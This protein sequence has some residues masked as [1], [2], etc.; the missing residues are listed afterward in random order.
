M[1]NYKKYWC[2]FLSIL[3][4]CFVFNSKALAADSSGNLCQQVQLKDNT[5]GQIIEFDLKNAD[6]ISVDSSSLLLQC[7]TIPNPIDP[8]QISINQQSPTSTDKIF[9][10]GDRVNVTYYNNGNVLKS[11]TIA[12]SKVAKERVLLTLLLT[13]LIFCFLIELLLFLVQA[14]RVSNRQTFPRIITVLCMGKDGRYSNSKTLFVFWFFILQICLIS[15]GILRVQNSG[16]TEF[17]GG[18]S[19]PQNLLTLSG[20]SSFT[21]L[22]AKGITQDQI[23]K[24]SEKD[25]KIPSRIKDFFSDLLCN[26]FKE[27]DLGDFQM[28]IINALLMISY[29][30]IFFGFLQVIPLHRSV[31]LP[32]I[33]STIT[34]GVG[35]SQGTYLIKKIL[36]SA[37]ANSNSAQPSGNDNLTNQK[38]TET[39]VSTVNDKPTLPSESDKK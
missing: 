32:D 11:I 17:L 31:F 3:A 23:S 12:E 33:D 20:I 38:I 9:A 6:I 24:G 37:S 18:I 29:I 19:I 14:N 26:D 15:F 7:P 22:S 28:T 30:L 21:L 5:T 25:V 1:R 34:T 2:V 10:P 36:S 8:I 4:I 39:Q 13:T 16:S 27:I 35:L